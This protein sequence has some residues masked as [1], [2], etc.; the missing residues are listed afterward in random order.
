M[1]EEGRPRKRRYS[2]ALRAAAAAAKRD[3]VID[4][5]A[6]LLARIEN[7]GSFSIELVAKEAGVTR[8]TVA[9]QLDL[10]RSARPSA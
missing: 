1:N 2:S 4:A 5:A 7:F 9:I 6:A 10:A 3:R 8:L